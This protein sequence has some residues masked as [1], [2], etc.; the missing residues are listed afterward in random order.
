MLGGIMN[1]NPS[2]DPVVVGRAYEDVW[3]WNGAAWGRLEL[4]PGPRPVALGNG[5]T[6]Y[7]RAAGELIHF[8]GVPITNGTYRNGQT[9]SLRL[10]PAGCGAG[11]LVDLNGD[12]IVD[13]GDYLEFLNLYEAQDPRVDFNQ[14]LM[15]DFAD[16]LEFL[17][18]YEA[19]C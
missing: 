1:F 3:E 14:D 4:A 12:G 9:W 10:P 13:F 19:G 17:N 5:G 7:D 8:G 2:S 15:V 16:Y 11:C 6:I 18:L